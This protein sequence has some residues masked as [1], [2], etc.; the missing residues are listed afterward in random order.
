MISGSALVFLP[1]L[2]RACVCAFAGHF[3]LWSAKHL[4]G[5]PSLAS[6]PRVFNIWVVSM[7]GAAISFHSAT[8]NRFL[9]PHPK[10]LPTFFFCVCMHVLIISFACPS[11]RSPP[12]MA[13]PRK[14][15]YPGCVPERVEGRE[16]RRGARGAEGTQQRETTAKL[17]KVGDDGSTR[18]LPLPMQYF[19]LIPLVS[20]PQ[21]AKHR[22][23]QRSTPSEQHQVPS[24]SHFCSPP[25]L[26]STRSASTEFRSSAPSMPS[27]FLT[28]ALW[29][30]F[31][32]PLTFAV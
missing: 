6:P 28:L 26:S 16:R 8:L 12:P 22:G 7:G 14:D 20:L 15:F 25:R 23:A 5:V 30:W 19:E 11:F 2:S 18:P 1:L 27:F 32:F 4:D 9:L 10:I 29:F 3:Q 31:A 13:L 24:R 21:D 17:Q